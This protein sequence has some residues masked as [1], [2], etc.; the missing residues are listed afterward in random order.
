MKKGILF[1]ATVCFAA[2]FSACQ[3]VTVGF[4]QSG[5]ARYTPDTL[6]IRR[7]L[8]EELDAFRIHNVAPWVSPKIQ[9]VMGTE[10]V[11]YELLDV[12]ATEGGNAALFRHLLTVRGGGKL[13]F[14]LISD[15]TPGR[16]TVSIQVSNEGYSQE[17]RDVFT[18]IV[19]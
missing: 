3:D 17:L 2:M 18:F 11:N 9:G 15:I 10:P 7:V 4:L 5:N 8:D 16:Y 6:V 12:K 19:K 1:L 14:P 13:E